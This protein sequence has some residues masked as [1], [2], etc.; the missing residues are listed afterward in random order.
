MPPLTPS[1][2]APPSPEAPRFDLWVHM[3]TPLQREELL[4][5]LNKTQ[6]PKDKTEALADALLRTQKVQIG[7]SVKKSQADKLKPEFDAAGLILIVSPVLTLAPIEEAPVVAFEVCPACGQSV[8]LTETRQC[9]SCK[10]SVDNVPLE[11]Q[12]KYKLQQKEKERLARNQAKRAQMELENRLREEIRTELEPRL[13]EEIRAELEVE[14]G[15]SATQPSR[16]KTMRRLLSFVWLVLACLTF[17][18]GYG[19]H[20]LIHSFS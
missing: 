7:A 6:L 19:T 11:A 15:L 13:R 4:D 2:D 9:P 20:L 18:A 16:S 14:Q 10:A 12:L 3:D 8:K 1:L 17:G 5:R